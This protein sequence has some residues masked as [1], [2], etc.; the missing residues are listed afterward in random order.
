M[1]F[2]IRKLLG[3]HLGSDQFQWTY[4]SHCA[5]WYKRSEYDKSKPCST[6]T[7]AQKWVFHASL[8]FTILSW[9]VCKLCLV[10]HDGNILAQIFFLDK[11]ISHT[12]L[13]QEQVHSHYTS[14]RTIINFISTTQRKMPFWLN[15]ESQSVYRKWWK[16]WH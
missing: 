2:L 15:S 12:L 6:K 16:L 13:F 5:N 14:T 7:C 3:L 11:G 4:Y 9:N 1:Q 10:S 8:H